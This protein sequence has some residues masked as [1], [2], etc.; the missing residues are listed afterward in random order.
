MFK[1]LLASCQ[2]DSTVSQT[3]LIS[4]MTAIPILANYILTFLTNIAV[5][6]MHATVPTMTAFDVY[7]GSILVA[8][9]GLKIANSALNETKTGV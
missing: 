7:G 2:I 6:I 5:S 1:T 9:L 8:M 4:Y 3:R